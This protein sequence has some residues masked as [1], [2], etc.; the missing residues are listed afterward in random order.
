MWPKYGTIVPKSV[1]KATIFL[2][3]VH[4]GFMLNA[5]FRGEEPLILRSDSLRG[6]RN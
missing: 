3:T 1:T 6:W 4:C 5:H 2:A